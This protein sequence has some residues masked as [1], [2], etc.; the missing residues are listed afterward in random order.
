MFWCYELAVYI[1]C[2]SITPHVVLNRMSLDRPGRG[3]SLDRPGRR[4][5]VWL[6]IGHPCT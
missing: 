2:L 5:G 6:E 1:V 4:V 3:M